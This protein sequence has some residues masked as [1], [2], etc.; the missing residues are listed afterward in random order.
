MK[1]EIHPEMREVIFR[2][3]V[4]G[5]LFKILSAVQTK[6]TIEFDGKEYPLVRAD[7]SS[8]SHPFYTGTERLLDTT[9]RV[10]KFGNKFGSLGA[11]K[12]KKK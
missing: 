2:D 9:G 5:S 8:T 6:E 1:A 4:N 3:S 10:E 7:V 11:F 12:K